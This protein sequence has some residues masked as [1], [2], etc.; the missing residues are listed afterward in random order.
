M[1]VVH[2]YTYEKVNLDTYTDSTIDWNLLS[3]AVKYYTDLEYT[4]IEVPWIVPERIIGLT[5]NDERK[6]LNAINNGFVKG[7]LVGS[8]EQSFLQLLLNDSH[9]L[10]T[11][12]GRF[13]ACSPCFREEKN[14]DYIHQRTFMKV[15]LF[16]NLPNHTSEFVKMIDEAETL[17]KKLAYPHTIRRELTPEGF[18]LYLGNIELGSYGKRSIIWNN[19]KIEWVYGPGLALPRFTQAMCCI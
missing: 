19:K 8:A 9:H 16:I 4:Y 11:E 13:V 6:I 1:A 15:E 12:G 7:S 2:D 14:Y 3:N 18:D 5:F 17:F 10:L